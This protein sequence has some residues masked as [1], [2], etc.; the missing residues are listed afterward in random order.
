M[1]IEIYFQEMRESVTMSAAKGHIIIM[2]TSSN[3]V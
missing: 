1:T 3:S 2:Q